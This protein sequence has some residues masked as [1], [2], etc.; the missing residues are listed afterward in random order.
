MAGGGGWASIT[1]HA[2]TASHNKQMKGQ[3]IESSMRQVVQHKIKCEKIG[4]EATPSFVAGGRR[5]RLSW[6]IHLCEVAWRS[7]KIGRPG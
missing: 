1:Q 7:S 3:L 6:S 2:F 5:I 4:G